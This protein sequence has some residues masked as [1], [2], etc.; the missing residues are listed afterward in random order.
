MLRS[1]WPFTVRGTIALIAGAA[2][3]AIGS[4]TDAPTF[5]FAGLALVLL[6]VICLASLWIRP[7]TTN[8]ARSIEEAV[9]ARG[10]SVAVR[11]R[12]ELGRP[13]ASRMQ[14][15]D[16]VRSVR[17]APHGV[18]HADGGGIARVTYSFTAGARG[19]LRLGPLV[20]T[21]VDVCALAVRRQSWGAETTLRVGPEIVD[22]E[23]ADVLGTGGTGGRPVASFA[24]NGTDDLV[25]RPYVHG[26]SRRRVHWKATAHR[27]E[28]M[29]RQEEQESAPNATVVLDRVASP[30]GG[31][32]TMLS[33]VVS[34]VAELQRAGYSVDV[35]DTDG[36]VIAAGF[37]T[38]PTPVLDALA[39]I[40]PASADA[41]VRPLIGDGAVG[42][43]VIV[44]GDRA[45]RVT[46]DLQDLT[47]RGRVIAV[48]SLADA[49][50]ATSLRRAGWKVGDL[51]RG[52]AAAWREA[53]LDVRG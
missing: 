14:W 39:P 46:Q 7:V 45:V 41:P 28:L 48:L 53:V 5:T 20:L 40:A 8:V 38:E 26:D 18:L 37:G 29:V 6:T 2:M 49:T 44:C 52:V 30:G 34:A 19:D 50:T 11:L 24:G 32:E 27:G 43:T 4:A 35:L 13:L 1:L 22:L 23:R 3:V 10:T 31:F 42:P 16:P 21:A 25:P 33:A 17:P 15:A 47:R 12:I 36:T 51:R 9:V